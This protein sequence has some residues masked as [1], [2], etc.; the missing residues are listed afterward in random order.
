MW[1]V[2]IVYIFQKIQ[3][4]ILIMRTKFAVISNP[5]SLVW[6]P[7]VVVCIKHSIGIFNFIAC[8]K[9][10]CKKMC[11]TSLKLVLVNDFLKKYLA[12]ELSLSLKNFDNN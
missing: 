12:S 4:E 5:M 3:H 1:T 2:V 9:K 10:V 11:Y 8:A 6:T 7:K